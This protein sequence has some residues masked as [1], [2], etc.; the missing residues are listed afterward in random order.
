M[1]RKSRRFQVVT[2]QSV[3]ESRSAMEV[4]R[5]PTAIYAR[6]SV[7]NAGRE[8]DES[9]RNQITLAHSYVL[10]H[11]E[12]ELIDTY[13]DNGFTGTNFDR[14]EF[15]RLMND[16]NHG[17]ISC[18]VVKDLSRFGRNYVETGIYIENIF[19]K[20]QVRLIA[21]NDNFDSSREEDRLSVS[22][23]VKNMVNEMYSRDQSRK[24][25]AAFQARRM[26]KD[27]LMTGKPPYG[28]DRNV[29]NTKL[30]P[31]DEAD[32]VRVMFQ[33]AAMGVS[34]ARIT[35]RMELIGAPLPGRNIRVKSSGKWTQASVKPILRNPAYAG[36]MC[37]GRSRSIG[38]AAHDGVERMPRKEWVVHRD[39]HY[40]LVPRPDWEAIDKSFNERAEEVKKTMEARKED[41]EKFGDDL[42]GL[43]WC[44]DC[45]R[46]M[47]LDRKC[48]AEGETYTHSA[49][50]CGAKHHEKC[51]Y[52]SVSTDFLK[53]VAM[54]QVR[55]HLSLMTDRAAV[56]RKMKEGE[57]G[58][59]VETSLD[60]KIA[61]VALKLKEA[62]DGRARLYEDYKDGLI[63]ETDFRT[64]HDKKVRGIGELE[65]ELKGLRT[66]KDEFDKVIKDF[67]DFIDN[68]KANPGED[69]FDGDLV[70]RTVNRIS[71]F[72]N[73]AVEISF[74]GD[75]LLSVIEEAMR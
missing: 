41:K 17:R 59:N 31:N 14:P 4:L 30:V 34:T 6:L 74:K 2:N 52:Q 65:A 38:I 68:A 66:K 60:K 45:D 57:A 12:F 54:E 7:E 51:C 15:T 28:Y 20:M 22:V 9:L 71:V 26:K 44:G 64:I 58:K 69:G 16:I 48:Y 36:D 56:I 5:I 32:Y 46:K 62:R 55:V 70:R 39:V 27:V 37:F 33:W 61:S 19:P 49:Y 35:E 53:V 73:G 24:I 1:A 10:E 18:I 75:D 11:P 50:E 40:P 63:D 29:E 21:I 43:V 67:L 3:T 47:F 23:P 42:Y 13:A 25:F 8:D 72:K